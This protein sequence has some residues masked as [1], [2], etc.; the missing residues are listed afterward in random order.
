M[1][2]FDLVIEY[3]KKAWWHIKELQWTSLE[4]TWTYFQMSTG[5]TESKNMAGVSTF[6]LNYIHKAHIQIRKV[7]QVVY[8]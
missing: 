1:N 2:G 4:K 8:F 6:I 5:E 3:A 7:S